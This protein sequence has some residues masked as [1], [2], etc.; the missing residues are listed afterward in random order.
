M[1]D[2]PYSG[3]NFVPAGLQNATDTGTPPFNSTTASFNTWLTGFLPSFSTF[4][5]DAVRAI[6][7]ASGTAETFPGYN[8]SYVRAGLIYRDSVLACPALWISKS[9]SEAGWMGEYTISPA[10]H[11]S[12]TIYVYPPLPSPLIPSRQN[13]VNLITRN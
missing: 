4:Q 9:A 7:P 12:D 1:T 10:R 13:F 8:T 3:E 2:A 11:A 6:Y 5:L